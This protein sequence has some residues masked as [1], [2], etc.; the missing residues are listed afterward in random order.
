[1]QRA[2]KFFDLRK[3]WLQKIWVLV[4][5]LGEFCKIE[6]LYASDASL[7]VFV[8]LPAIVVMDVI[9]C[10]VRELF[11]TGKV[12]EFLCEGNWRWTLSGEM[13]KFRTVKNPT[14]WT[15]CFNCLASLF[16]PGT[17]RR[18]PGNSSRSGMPPTLW[19]SAFNAISG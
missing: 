10:R 11:L 18:S 3:M 5:F 9:V 15:A 6:W 14:W 16:L 7:L 13:P 12:E 8:V 2:R 4:F 1:M 19:R 17:T